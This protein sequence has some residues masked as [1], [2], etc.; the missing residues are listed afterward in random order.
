MVKFLLV[1]L[2]CCSYIVR[3]TYQSTNRNMTWEDTEYTGWHNNSH[4]PFLNEVKKNLNSCTHTHKTKQW[5]RKNKTL[6]YLILTA[7]SLT[8]IAFEILSVTCC[9]VWREINLHAHIGP[10]PSTG[11]N[12]VFTG[13]NLWFT[14]SLYS[15][16]HSVNAVIQ[17]GNICIGWRPENLFCPQVL[18]LIGSFMNT[19]AKQFWWEIKGFFVSCVFVLAPLTGL[20]AQMV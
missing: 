4:K 17:A 15:L 7:S 2:K 8:Q 13:H 16:N 18:T 3:F 10:K 20:K 9:T 19:C 11:V 1:G 14:S 6:M 5:R 12:G